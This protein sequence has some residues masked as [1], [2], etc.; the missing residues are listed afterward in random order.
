MFCYFVKST[1]LDWEPRK[2]TASLPEGKESTV[3]IEIQKSH[4]A[5]RLIF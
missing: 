4:T 5:L 1:R 2:D 3:V